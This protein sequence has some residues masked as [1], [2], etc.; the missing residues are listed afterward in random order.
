MSAAAVLLS[1]NGEYVHLS[2]PISFTNPILFQRPFIF[3]GN[4]TIR[5]VLR[6][7]SLPSLSLMLSV[8]LR[9]PHGI[10]SLHRSEDTVIAAEEMQMSAE[11]FCFGYRIQE[12]TVH[13]K[14]LYRP[15]PQLLALLWSIL[16]PAQADLRAVPDGLR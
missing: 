11:C 10:A 3:A 6:W 8:I 5:S 15:E 16:S 9:N 13:R 4:P 14:Q 12:P 1:V 2:K 7:I